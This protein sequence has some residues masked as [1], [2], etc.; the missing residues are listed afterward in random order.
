M[1]GSVTVGGGLIF[2]QVNTA[3]AIT[4]TNTITLTGGIVDSAAANNGNPA[5]TTSISARSF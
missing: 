4:G 3:Y 2:S 5:L 1:T